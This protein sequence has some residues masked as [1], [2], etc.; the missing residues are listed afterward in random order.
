MCSL[1]LDSASGPNEKFLVLKLLFYF[2]LTD[3]LSSIENHHPGFPRNIPTRT[4]NTRCLKHQ[5]ETSLAPTEEEEEVEETTTRR[6]GPLSPSWV[7]S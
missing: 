5:E 7:D 6:D 1:G 3:I 2:S 4:H